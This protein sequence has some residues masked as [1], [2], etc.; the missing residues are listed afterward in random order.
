MPRG[1][2]RVRLSLTAIK[3]RADAEKLKENLKFY[4]VWT[5]DSTP[6]DPVAS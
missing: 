3:E 6:I 2:L 1:L 4:L 5:A